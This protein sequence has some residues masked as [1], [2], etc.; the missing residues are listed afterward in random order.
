[1]VESQ[2]NPICEG[3]GGQFV[4]LFESLVLQDL[5][6]DKIQINTIESTD[7]SVLSASTN[8]SIV[9][10]GDYD[11]NSNTQEFDIIAQYIGIAGSTILTFYI[12]DGF[13]TIELTI[14]FV[15]SPPP[16]SNVTLTEIEACINDDLINMH[17]AVGGI[18]SGQFFYNGEQIP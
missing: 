15:V 5:D 18:Y 14:P 11:P 17:E 7:Y 6:F 1:I 3:T 9:P 16:T 13:E 4:S 8:F 2:Q 10:L 12:S